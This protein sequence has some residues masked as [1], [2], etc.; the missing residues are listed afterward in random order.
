M[1]LLRRLAPCAVLLLL[2]SSGLA[3]DPAAR[4]QAL[5]EDAYG[6]CTKGEQLLGAGDAQGKE[7][8]EQACERYADALTQVEALPVSAAKKALVRQVGHYNTACARSLLGQEDEAFAALRAALEAG[9]DDLTRL[10]EDPSLAPLRASPRFQNLLAR[11]R[12]RLDGEAVAAAQSLLSP[13]PLFPY[14]FD[15]KTLDGAPLK[16]ADLRGKV[17]IVD[18]WGTWCPPCRQE[19]PHFVEL[20]REFGDLL[21]VVGMTFEKEQGEAAVAGVRR[22]AREL[23]VTYPLVMADRALLQQVPNLE[24]FPTT[25]II[26]RQGRVRAREVGYREHAYLRQLVIALLAEEA[27]KAPEAPAPETPETPAPAPEGEQPP[28][29]EGLGPF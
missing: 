25:L 9:Y 10:V 23:G 11:T 14:D 27:G 13:E 3:Q 17:V 12:A 15:V 5:L 20:G 4:V 28:E 18:Y 1:N 6:L 21:E 22:F 26:D 2:A 24:G 8:L 29:P 16:L 19:I 7:L